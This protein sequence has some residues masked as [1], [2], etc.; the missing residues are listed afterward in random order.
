MNIRMNVQKS[1]NAPNIGSAQ[2][3]FDCGGYRA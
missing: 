3:E 1:K 2:Q